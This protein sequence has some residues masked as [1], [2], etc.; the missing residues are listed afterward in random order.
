MKK[1]LA[2]IFTFAG[3]AVPGCGETD[4]NPQRLRD[5]IPRNIS[6]INRE[7]IQYSVDVNCY[8]D[9]IMALDNGEQ[10]LHFYESASSVDN[11]VGLGNYVVFTGPSGFTHL[12]RY[13]K[14][15]KPN[16][17]L[18]FTDLG[19]GTREVTY[20]AQTNVADLVIAGAANTVRVDTT[21]GRLAID[22]TGDGLYK[23]DQAPIVDI[24]GNVTLEEDL[25][26]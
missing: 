13:D 20:D 23:A 4:S 9:R 12:L 17:T 19:T 2:T 14:I 26:Q 6:F 21:S 16:R 8:A 3:F 18:T 10:R 24:N 7:G 25:T 15:D 22:Q 1:T 5:H 11:K